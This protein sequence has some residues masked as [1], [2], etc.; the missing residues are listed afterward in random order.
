VKLPRQALTPVDERLVSRLH[1][2]ARLACAAVMVAAVAVLL[3]WLLGIE[4][5]RAVLPGMVAMN[6]ATAV[7]FVLLGLGLR[8]AV[9][10]RRGA[11][12]PGAAALVV[13]V[14]GVRLVGY[15]FAL[16]VPVDRVLFPD[17]L[18]AYEPPNRMA[19]NTAMAFLLAGLALALAAGRPARPGRP[20]RT[21][22]LVHGLGIA[23]GLLGLLALVGYA[24]GRSAL[25]GLEAHIPMAL[26]TSVAFALLGP[27]FLAVDPRRGLARLGV[28]ASPGG[29]AYRRLLPAALLLPLG[30]SWLGV[31]GAQAGLFGAGVGISLMII[32]GT[33]VLAGLIAW[34]CLLLDQA[35]ARRRGA[36]EHARRLH[37]DLRLQT[38]E[39]EAANQ[40]LAAFSYSVSHD[41]RAPLRSVT[42]FG[43]ILLEDHATELPD[44][45]RDYLGRIVRAGTR[46]ATL[47][48][49]LLA[50][51]RTTKGELVR[52]EVSV[53]DVA[54]NVL[55]E[56]RQDAPERTVRAEVAPDLVTLADR[57]LL[58]TVLENLL[59]NAWKYSARRSA[60]HVQV[61]QEDGAFF[62]RDNGVGFDMAHAANLFAPFHRL[63]A[64]TDFEGTGI[65]LA[66][67]QRIVARHGGRVWARSE[68]DQGATFYFTLS[69]E[70]T[71]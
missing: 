31:A 41:L 25:V 44:E 39:L 66:T 23:A 45:A 63:H 15:A 4:A 61:G 6:P 52:E 35:D 69:P 54:S 68:P 24:L 67:V 1:R 37:E 33:L 30:L 51:A 11:L 64:D 71:P 53:S 50:L 21:A 2:Y 34:T 48:D 46:M 19:P 17:A 59:G 12:L 43:Q 56:L 29:M 13:A 60:A 57:R 65:G 3:G 5:L 40:E 8:A 10:R 7:C 49:D 14:A 32:V 26:N 42:S 22:I 55:T 20:G 28:S 9:E 16:D 38:A 47:I 58:R 18:A 70:E 62:V 27:G 36:D